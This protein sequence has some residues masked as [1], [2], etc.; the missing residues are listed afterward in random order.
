[1]LMRSP[2]SALAALVAGAASVAPITCS[3]FTPKDCESRQITACTEVL[4][5]NP[6]AIWALGNRAIAYRVAGEYDRA[7]A[8]FSEAI[9]LGATSPGTYLERG[10]TYQAKDE[11]GLAIADF[12][13][14]IARSPTPL[15]QAHFGKAIALEATGQ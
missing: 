2:V 1:M 8:D 6:A 12:D 10:L 9:R 5:D 13:L 15:V 7:I 3:A 14:A 11:H 4:R